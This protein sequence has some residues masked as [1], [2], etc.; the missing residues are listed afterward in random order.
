MPRAKGGM[1]IE[2]MELCEGEDA[3]NTGPF[4][5]FPKSAKVYNF[6]L[7]ASELMTCFCIK[8][9]SYKYTFKPRMWSQNS[10]PHIFYHMFNHS[11]SLH[12]SKKLS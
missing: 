11:L 12:G 5:F 4:F 9:N 7:N 2:Q 10:T 8:M 6:C 1:F 3:K